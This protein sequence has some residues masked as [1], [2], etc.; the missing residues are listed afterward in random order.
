MIK[1]VL[2]GADLAG[3]AGGLPLGRVD[4]VVG[5]A[6]CERSAVRTARCAAGT[7]VVAAACEVARVCAA[8]ASSCGAPA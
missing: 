4:N 3:Q 6:S 7:V 1:W 8:I 2:K 5:V